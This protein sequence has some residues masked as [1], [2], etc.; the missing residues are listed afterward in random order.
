MQNNPYESPALSS[1]ATDTKPRSLWPALWMFVRHV[2]FLFII[3]ASVVVIGSWM[4]RN[5]EYWK[6]RK[7]HA[8][9]LLALY[10]GRWIARYW[11]LS[12][13][14]APIYLLFLIGVQSLNHRVQGARYAWP[15]IF[16]TLSI[17][18]VLL[19]GFGFILPFL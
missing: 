2:L 4:E 6:I 11:Y 15:W 1:A 17:S 13:M 7:L 16:W 12:L 3:A 10:L 18:V 5:L 9:S 19:L 8:P 14:A